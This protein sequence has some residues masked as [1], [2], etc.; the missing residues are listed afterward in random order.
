MPAGEE[1]DAQPASIASRQA[2]VF[3][4]GP[5]EDCLIES[6]DPAVMRNVDKSQLTDHRYPPIRSGD[7]LR[8]KLDRTN[9]S[10]A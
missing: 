10:D 1:A 9:L 8:M 4:T 5:L 7:H 2:I 6:L 3:F